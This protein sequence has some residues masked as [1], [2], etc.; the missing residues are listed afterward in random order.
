VNTISPVE[1]EKSP[2][3][4]MEVKFRKCLYNEGNSEVHHQDA[5]H[6]KKPLTLVLHANGAARVVKVE[7]NT[8]EIHVRGY[9][10]HFIIP[11][12][13]VPI[14]AE[15]NPNKEYDAAEYATEEEEVEGSK[16]KTYPSGFRDRLDVTLNL[17]HVKTEYKPEGAGSNC[18]YQ[19]GTSK[20]NPKTGNVETLTHFE[21]EIPEITIAKGSI[22]FE[23]GE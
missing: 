5:V 21:L 13:E 22:G 17:A 9:T 11:E 6:F 19:R 20:V 2:N 10:C 4:K 15:K 7:E 1:A 12:Q 16:L 23:P 8:P 18:E 14:S 3:L